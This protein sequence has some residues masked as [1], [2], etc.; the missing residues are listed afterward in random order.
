[1]NKLLRTDNRRPSSEIYDDDDDDDVDDINNDKDDEVRIR[2]H[3]VVLFVRATCPLIS[4]SL[5]TLILLQLD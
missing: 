4:V 5:I 3:V 2:K 1:M